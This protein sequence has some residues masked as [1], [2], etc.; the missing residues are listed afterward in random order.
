MI[1]HGCIKIHLKDCEG[2]IIIMGFKVL[3]IMQYLIREIL[4]KAVL[5]IHAR[6]VKIKSLSIQMLQ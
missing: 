5:G 2:W 4:M 1:F 3:L 6:D